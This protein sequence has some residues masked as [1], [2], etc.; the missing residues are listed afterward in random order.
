MGLELIYSTI[1]EVITN[2]VIFYGGLLMAQLCLYFYHAL[3]CISF[4]LQK[5]LPK[6]G[7]STIEYRISNIE[8]LYSMV[9]LKRVGYQLSIPN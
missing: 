5:V 3:F 6:V 7:G 9:L 4:I 1:G 2:D 8:V